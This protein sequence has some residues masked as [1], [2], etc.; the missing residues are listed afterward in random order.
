MCWQH[1]LRLCNSVI[2]FLSSEEELFAAEDFKQLFIAERDGH[3]RC[4]KKLESIERKLDSF[5]ASQSADGASKTS[6][7]AEDVSGPKW[8]EWLK[9][10]HAVGDFDTQKNQYI[11]VMDVV[12]NEELDC[13]SSLRGVP[14]KMILDFDPKSEENGFY[15]EFTSKE[16]KMSNLASMFTPAELQQ[17]T[18]KS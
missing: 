10:R 17:C 4:E 5:I 6:A 11:L 18:M 13:Y 16:G 3:Y 14:W 9:F 1:I 12:Q 8:D 15:R 7:G 2:Y